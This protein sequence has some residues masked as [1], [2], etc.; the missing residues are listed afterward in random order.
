MQVGR[1]P[2]AIVTTAAVA[3]SVLTPGAAGAAPKPAPAGSSGSENVIVL[4][5]DQ[6]SSVPNTR[7]NQ[8]RRAQI[9][10]ADQSSVAGRAQKDG[11]K[12]IRG[13]ST[14]NAVSLAA[15]PAAVSRLQSDP[16]VAAIVP[17]RVITAP[18][19]NAD[20]A[21]ARAAAAS[22]SGR[23]CSTDPIKPTY[24]PEALQTMHVA[25][26]DGTKQALAYTDGAG[27]KV[28]WMADGLDPNIVGFTRG[29]RSI[30]TDYQDFTG[31]GPTVPTGA[32]EA[33]G[34]A[35]SIAAQ[36][37]QVYN[38]A[39]FVN[40]S[41]ALPN[42]CYIKVEGV[43]PGASLVGLKVFGT[44]HTSSESNFVRAIEYA[45]DVDHVDVLNQSFGEGNPY[46][47][48]ALDPVSLANDA[49]VQAGTTVVASTGDSGITNTLDS[50][51]SN[52][53]VIAAGATTTYR[54]IEQEAN[55]G[56]NLPGVKGYA[57]DNISPLSSA[58]FAQN[59]K[60]PDLVAPGDSG[61][62]YC[63]TD[64]ALY[65]ECTNVK[66][67]PTGSPIQNF[68]GTSQ[69]SPLIAGAAAL[70]IAAYR[71]T[72]PGA[73]NPSPALVKRILMSTARDLGH[74]AQLQGAGEV[75]ALAAVRAAMSAPTSS[76]A[77]P[78][79]AT[80][81]SLLR[82]E[83][84]VHLSGKA[85]A[86]VSTTVHLRNDSAGT[87]K[88]SAHTR[89]L[90]ALV[91]R[92][93]GTIDFDPTGLPSFPNLAGAPRNYTKV[94]F[95]VGAGI[96]RLDGSMAWNGQGATYVYNS[97]IDP[98]GKLQSYSFPQGSGSYS[99]ID[100]RYPKAGKWTMYVWGRSTFTG[101]IKYEIDQSRFGRYGSVSPTT[102][103]V[104]PGHA[105]SFTVSMPM[106]TNPGDTAAS[107]QFHT[108]SGLTQ[109]LP[110]S[111]RSVVTAVHRGVTT[112]HGS[113]TGGN[114]RTTSGTATSNTYYLDVPVG[115]PSLAVGFTLAGQTEPNEVIKAYLVSP[116]NEPLAVQTNVVLNAD[117]TA[118]AK[119]GGLQLY[120]AAPP[121]GRW[122]VVLEAVDP[123]SGDMIRQPFTGYVSTVNQ[124]KSVQASLPTSS[125]TVLKAGKPVT[126]KLRVT[127]TGVVTRSYF[128]DPRL[129]VRGAYQ[130]AS[131]VPGDDLRNEHVADGSAGEWIVPTR[132]SRLTVNANA[133]IPIGLDTGWLNPGSQDAGQPELFSASTNGK[134]TNTITASEIA[135]GPWYGTAGY[136]GPF[137]GTGP[138]GTVSYSARVVTALFD[139]SVI[140]STGD[141]WVNA[142]IPAPASAATT[143]GGS[144]HR[145]FA[146]AA[147]AEATSAATGSGVVA[148]GPLTLAPGK[149]G[150]VTVQITPRASEKGQIV[151]GSLDLDTFDPY[152]GTGDLVTAAQYTY[153]VG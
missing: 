34:D 26:V 121:A 111:L 76:G 97:F 114:G 79:G 130:L 81:N 66:T 38:V 53:S 9:L 142:L 45:V 137:P 113:F 138:T 131:Q 99:H 64:I 150:T 129:H 75:D 37:N 125:R 36:P 60:I 14:I 23:A 51:A 13:F 96:S 112:F 69:A 19:T 70:V 71:K 143:T 134:A 11:G 1:R 12:N 118:L 68:G 115:Q 89:A 109:S 25:S 4:L 46:P 145:D 103:S 30:F 88:V 29:G 40:E 7:A 140:T 57:S 101:P 77:R 10:H 41:H 32:A 98:D 39:D 59:G 106:A 144:V 124:A 83:G 126:V 31:D 63:S 6:H 18:T 3:M 117:A 122:H 108:A 151:S 119:V 105:A 28:A 80:G 85:G 48:A 55:Y 62:A 15:D 139:P 42:G 74:P 107:V 135:Q 21:S 73:G 136:I 5:K 128:T 58:G 17:D 16:A 87:Q 2:L 100:V 153:K 84:Q 95:T 90:T 78:A 43:A 133:T 56:T 72:H 61:W 102:Q 104:A 20:T 120:S 67:T 22:G 123:V 92:R 141:F 132:S 82:D 147:K 110:L 93:S 24:E 149:T 94:T 47:D 50:P 8:G 35:S 152:L 65:E 148:T 54:S 86:V 27:V 127:N 146:A 52:P 116:Q 91:A 33:F 49:A 44:D